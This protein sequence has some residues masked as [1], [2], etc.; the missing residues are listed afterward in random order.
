MDLPTYSV[1]PGFL[2]N[3]QTT[4]GFLAK[5]ADFGVLSLKSPH[6]V[7]FMKNLFL[8]PK[9]QFSAPGLQPSIILKE[10]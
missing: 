9:S 4:V 5:N 7:I 1:A 10:Y 2:C 3:Y 6:L 8:R